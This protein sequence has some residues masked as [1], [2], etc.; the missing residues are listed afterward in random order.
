MKRQL[1]QGMI[2]HEGSGK[3]EK[4]KKEKSEKVLKEREQSLK[5]R[6]ELEHVVQELQLQ[7]QKVQRDIA[8]K[9][10]EIKHFKKMA[11]DLAE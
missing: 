3:K 9:D 6:L 10:E 4:K 2:S 7:L 5:E 1:L 11:R 8:Y